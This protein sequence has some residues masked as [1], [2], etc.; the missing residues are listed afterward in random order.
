[1]QTVLYPQLLLTSMMLCLPAGITGGVISHSGFE[2]RFF[3]H[4]S[5]LLVLLAG[6]QPLQHAHDL[7]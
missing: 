6:Q 4:V 2:A 3:G 7:R 5:A 1:M